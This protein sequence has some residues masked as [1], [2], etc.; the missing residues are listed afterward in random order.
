MPKAPGPNPYNYTQPVRDPEL[1]SGRSHELSEIEYYLDLAATGPDPEHIALIG[2]RST[3]KSSLLYRVSEFAEAR[4]YLPVMIVL[5]NST[6]QNPFFFFR[7]LTDEIMTK[8]VRKHDFYGGQFEDVYGVYRLQMD[9]KEV[10]VNRNHVRLGFPAIYIGAEKA[11]FKDAVPQNAL[12]TDL[13]ELWEEGKRHGLLKLAVL[14]D[15]ANELSKNV[16]LLQL[17]RNV[18]TTL[19]GYQLVLSGTDEMFSQMEDAYSPI[20]RNFHS[21]RVGAFSSVAETADC[22]LRPLPPEDRWR[23]RRETVEDI[24]RL[25]GGQPYEIRLVSHFMYRHYEEQED[26]DYIHL[27]VPVFEKVAAELRGLQSTQRRDAI[28]RL[29]SLKQDDIIA[30]K[31]LVAYPFSSLNEVAN[32]IECFRVDRVSPAVVERRTQILREK[33]SELVAG[34]VVED[35]GDDRFALPGDEFEQLY[36]KYHAKAENVDWGPGA[37]M[38]MDHLTGH[39]LAGVARGIETDGVRFVTTA[40]GTPLGVVKR[41]RRQCDLLRELQATSVDPGIEHYEV[42][43]DVFPF[44]YAAAQIEAS[45]SLVVCLG[46]VS[47]QRPGQTIELRVWLSSP[48]DSDLILDT[49]RKQEPNLSCLGFKSDELD[50]VEVPVLSTGRLRELAESLDEE[51]LKDRMP[52]R[53][54]RELRAFKLVDKALRHAEE[55]RKEMDEPESGED[56]EIVEAGR[57]ALRTA[58]GL[59]GDGQSEEAAAVFQEV[60]A[61]E[62]PGQVMAEAHNDLGY[63][64]AGGNDPEHAQYHLE[65]AIRLFARNPAITWVNLAFVL[66]CREQ[67]E[68][69]KRAASLAI[70]TDDEA[71]GASAVFL[72]CH[73]FSGEHQVVTSHE[74]RRKVKVGAVTYA[75]L[76]ALEALSGDMP[77]AI[78]TAREGAAVYPDE[79]VTNWALARLL[80]AARDPSAVELYRRLVGQFPETAELLQELQLAER[81]LADG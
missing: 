55:L 56:T 52:A 3:G 76:A 27:D 53:L 42:I 51:S 11:G 1:F 66:G 50:V 46:V 17:I 21:I 63:V 20:P 33:A 44:L 40:I 49:L 58:V 69:A 29:R 12:I 8:G 16:I 28:A 65:E 67:F 31:S 64:L 77:R 75:N 37:D 54:A 23:V 80:L 35:L 4:K 61:A 72:R 6:V 57:K 25:S 73:L 79:V 10:N 19:P 48:A 7:Q 22:I 68:K 59:Y 39:A 71:G 14:I 45:S 74:V 43:A 2:P 36:V 13:Q 9:A 15:E 24:H 62:Y 18:F 78:E 30:L 26:A 38:E 81:E 60:L 5:N 34:Q 47:S 32:F 41:M 70:L